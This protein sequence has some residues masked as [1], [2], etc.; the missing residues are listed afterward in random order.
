MQ[1]H[2]SSNLD[3]FSESVEDVPAEKKEVRVTPQAPTLD[4]FS[5]M[6]P[7]DLNIKNWENVEDLTNLNV[8]EEQ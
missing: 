5:L 2:N 7:I 6:S 4:S 3:R 8:A 1:S